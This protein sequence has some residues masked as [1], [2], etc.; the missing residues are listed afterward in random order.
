MPGYRSAY[1]AARRLYP[2]ALEAS[3]RWDRL[4][5]EE[6]ERYKRQARRYADQAVSYARDAAERAPRRRR[7]R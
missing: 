4:P 5:P 6:K 2:L 3:R 1:R 7:R